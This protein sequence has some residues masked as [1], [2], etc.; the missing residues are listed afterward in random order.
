MKQKS[1]VSAANLLQ[2][3]K[4]LCLIFSA[5][6]QWIFELFIE[7]TESLFMSVTLWHNQFKY[8]VI[9]WLAVNVFCVNDW[10]FEAKKYTFK[11]TL[12]LYWIQLIIIHYVYEIYKQQMYSDKKQMGILHKYYCKYLCDDSL[13]SVNEILFLLTQDRKQ[14][15]RQLDH[16]VIHWF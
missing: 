7:I 16:E 15:K 4:K 14:V 13:L 11:L 3:D 8:V 2:R 10:M 12:Y 6:H 9:H 5:Q 1:E